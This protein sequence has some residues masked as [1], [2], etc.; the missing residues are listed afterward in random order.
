M[1]A[2]EIARLEEDAIRRTSVSDWPG[3]RVLFEQALTFEMPALRRAHILKNVAGTYWKERN[4]PAAA[5][6]A[7]RAIE[8]LNSAGVGGVEA[9]KLRNELHNICTFTS[10]KLP[11]SKF[12]YGVVFLAGLYWGVSVAS[13]A[14]MDR[15][16]VFLGPPL[17]CLV[18]A[19]I[20][21][22]GLNTRTLLGAATLYVNFLFSFSI[23]YGIAAAGV[24]RFGY[25]PR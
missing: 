13:G 25:R 6:T 14:P 10:G 7:Q 22:G 4:S 20:A 18:N 11:V 21:V 16:L 3:A 19:W 5:A 12:W 2:D 9:E 8:V 24:F 23:G 17:L 1:A 15:T